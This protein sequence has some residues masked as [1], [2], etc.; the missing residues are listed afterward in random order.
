MDDW[1]FF[2]FKLLNQIENQ[3][4]VQSDDSKAYKLEYKKSRC[5]SRVNS[6]K[7]SWPFCEKDCKIYILTSGFCSYV[8][9]YLVT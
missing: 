8:K 6:T 2:I 1:N 7:F 9:Y 4:D 5:N 3:D